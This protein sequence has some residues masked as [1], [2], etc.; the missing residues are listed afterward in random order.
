MTT[1]NPSPSPTE[2]GTSAATAPQAASHAPGEWLPLAA[3]LAVVG[4]C[5]RTL[6]RWIRANKV[7]VRWI[8]GRQLVELGE[9][10]RCAARPRAGRVTPAA[11][12]VSPAVTPPSAEGFIKV[13]ARLTEVLERVERLERTLPLPPTSPD[14][15][16][17]SGGDGAH[18]PP[19]RVRGGA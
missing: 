12:G 5:K 10:R 2:T 11:D 19:G 3:A 15:A 1:S 9:V 4:V 13:Q 7:R 6:R 14:V 17:A 18:A 16:G 8:A